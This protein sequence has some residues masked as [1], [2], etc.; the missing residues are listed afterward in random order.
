MLIETY[1]NNYPISPL[2]KNSYLCPIEYINIGNNDQYRRV[3]FRCR[4][5]CNL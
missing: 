3:Y 2:E 1:K 5:S 4:V